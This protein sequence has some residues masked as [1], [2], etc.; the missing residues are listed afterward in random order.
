MPETH[1]DA[2]DEGTGSRAKLVK[3]SIPGHLVK[4]T[5]PAVVGVAA[6]MSVGIIDAYFVGQ[7]GPS[8]LAAISFIF[9]VITALQSLG[10]GVMVGVNSVVSR[11]LGEGNDDS[12]LSR[13][14]LGMALGLV[15]GL[16]TGL[17][18]YLLRQP[19]FELMQA[20]A[21]ILPLIDEYMA[22]Y[23][24]GFP[25]MMTMMGMNGVLR[26]QGAA[27]ANT[28][29]LLVYSAANWVLDP[30]LITGMFGIEGFGIAGAAYATIGGWLIAIVA[31]F[32]LLGRYD[33][34]FRPSAMTQCDVRT[35]MGAITRV[36]GPAAFTNSINPAGLAVLTSF[37]AAEGAAAVAGFGVG[38]RLQSFAV[39][40]LLA[41]SGSIGAIVGQN[42]GASQYDRARNALV[43][44]GLFCIGYGLAAA[45]VIFM[46]REWFA[47]IF[48]EEADVTEA[49]VSYLAISVWGYAGFGVLIVVNGALNAI[50]RAG[51]ALALS[52]TRVLLV[53]VPFAWLLRGALGTEAVYWAE[54]VANVSGG[55]AAAAIAWWVL[56]K[57]P[58]TGEQSGAS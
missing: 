36:A 6:I 35:Q 51:N 8:E 50:D 42:W 25:L 17:L 22:P 16:A 53:M 55:L 39:V 40:P 54:L 52:L 43:Q 33:L 15:A 47:Q 4:Q 41:L 18:L 34:P 12:A 2:Q 28:A 48:S 3:G 23:A 57:R 1:E 30:L 9:P 20:D 49:A 19:L 31:A 44:A 46:A 29:V 56:W 45:I 37:L 27:K 10:V 32:L 7:L 11:A 38:G 24:L 13:A 21:D 14:N 5:T 58:G 26:G